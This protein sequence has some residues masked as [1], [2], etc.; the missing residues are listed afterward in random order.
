MTNRDLS[1]LGLILVGCIV[2]IIG[3]R[4]DK[5]YAAKGLGLDSNRVTSAKRGRFVFTAAGL[6]FIVVG[7]AQ[8]LKG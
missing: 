4:A 6:V 2:I 3:F 7:I 5:F 1:A 8:L